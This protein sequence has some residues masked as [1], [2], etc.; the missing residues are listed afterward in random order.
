[1]LPPCLGFINGQEPSEFCCSSVRNLKDMG[2]TKDD[3]VA[4][5]NCVKQVTRIITYDP[6]RITLL[7]KK[8]GVDSTF[9]PI[10]KEYNCKDVK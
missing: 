10:D 3:R 2:K 8:C 5:C 9:P 6:K 4:M 7:P 1:M